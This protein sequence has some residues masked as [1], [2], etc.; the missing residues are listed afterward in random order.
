MQSKTSCR[1]RK[2]L[3]KQKKLMIQKKYGQQN[4]IEKYKKHR[5]ERQSRAEQSTS[6]QRRLLES[7]KKVQMTKPAT[8]PATERN[9]RHFFC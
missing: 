7:D 5:Q 9:V 3:S 2:K 4:N 8:Q 1:K 6:K